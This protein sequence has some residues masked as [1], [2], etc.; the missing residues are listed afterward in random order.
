MARRR[1]IPRYG[2]VEIRGNYYYK[3]YVTDENGK[4]VALYG[5]TR[6][7]LYD[8]EL[9]A[10]DQIDNA[11]FRRKSPTVEEY[12][13]KWL[14]MQSVHVRSTTLID[15][16]SKV[17][18]HIIAELG[19]MRIADV[20]QDDI[21]LALV[22]VSKKSVS[23]YK[24]V[25]ILYKSIFKSAMESRLIDDNPTVYLATEGGVPQKM[26]D[27]LSDEQAERLLAA[28]EGLQTYVFVML[29]L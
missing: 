25:V 4:R 18:R 3:T 6:E 24:S 5:K 28:I 19:D 27:S 20:T 23:V 16:T 14:L 26:K 21:Q 2:S 8:K 11:S 15:Y 29:G 17:R 22:P 13:E 1:Q 12:A 10:L 9:E 7:E